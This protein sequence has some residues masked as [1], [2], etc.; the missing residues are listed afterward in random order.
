MMQ[1]MQQQM[2]I[3]QAQNRHIKTL[4]Q[5]TEPTEIIDLD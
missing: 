3:Q 4:G 2:M 5:N 1:M